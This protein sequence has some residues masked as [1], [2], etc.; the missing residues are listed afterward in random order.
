MAR[1]AP[2]EA[3]SPRVSRARL[4]ADSRTR[5]CLVLVEAADAAGL[6]GLLTAARRHLVASSWIEFPRR[7]VTRRNAGPDEERVSRRAFRDLQRSGAF[8]VSWEAGGEG[9][10]VPIA[11]RKALRRG[12]MVVASVPH[13]LADAR[14]AWARIHRVRITAGT[15]RV[16]APLDPRACLRR[17]LGPEMCARVN[18]AAPAAIDATVHHQG[19]VSAVVERLSATLLAFAAGLTTRDAAQ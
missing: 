12:R 18:L 14:T 9:F 6:E 16:R 3:L 4:R 1:T 11:A 17:T 8:L 5:G 2:I 15:D 13:G 10:A 7:I 19:N